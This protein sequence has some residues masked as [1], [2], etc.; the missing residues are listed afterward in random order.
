MQVIAE[1][2]VG[3]PGMV[4]NESGLAGDLTAATAG[5]GDGAVAC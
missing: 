1:R 3:N 2:Q 4:G 5:P